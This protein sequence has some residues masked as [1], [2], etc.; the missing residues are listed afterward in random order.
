[1]DS[2]GE[3]L[4]QGP[5]SFYKTKNSV[6]I[7]VLDHKYCGTLEVIAFEPTLGVEAPRVYLNE[8]VVRS[9]VESSA[10]DGYLRSAKFAA[11]RKG[12]APN[13]PALIKEAERKAKA[14]YILN[15]L[16]IKSYSFEK[17]EIV[18]Q[19]QFDFNDRDNEHGGLDVDTMIVEKPEELVPHVPDRT[20]VMYVSCCA[21]ECLVLPSTHFHLEFYRDGSGKGSSKTS[22]K[23]SPKTSAKAGSPQPHSEKAQS[24]TANQLEAKPGLQKRNSSPLP[25]RPGLF[26]GFKSAPTVNT[27]DSLSDDSASPSTTPTH[28]SIARRSTSP[29]IPF[30]PEGFSSG[31]SPGRRSWRDTHSEGG[32]TKP[33]CVMPVHEEEPEKEEAELEREAETQTGL[34]DASFSGKRTLFSDQDCMSIVSPPTSS[35]I[36]GLHA[37]LTSAPS[38]GKGLLGRIYNSFTTVYSGGSSSAA[39][40][41][42]E[43]KSPRDGNHNSSGGGLTARLSRLVMRRGSRVQDCEDEDRDSLAPLKDLGHTSYKTGA[44]DMSQESAR[45]STVS[46]TSSTG[47][48]NQSPATSWKSWIGGTVVP[49]N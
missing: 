27:E 44:L 21:A 46:R 19:L 8:K 30:H 40:S 14:T 7:I 11:M 15:R 5:K 48:D 31:R 43:I 4:L 38:E 25:P 17:K 45:T 34:T 28:G 22:P 49:S 2:V 18:V 24:R 37:P 13:L 32:S 41:S 29:N 12:E 10:I 33:A 26:S 9:R 47:L 35:K 6:D 3:L 36:G 39:A 20:A 16:F 42:D 23:G 1:M